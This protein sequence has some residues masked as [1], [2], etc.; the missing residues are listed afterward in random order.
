MRVAVVGAGKMGAHHARV[1]SRADGAELAGVLDV[2]RSA[3]ERVAR[4]HG[5]AVFSS[6]DEALARAD[7][8]VLATPTALHAAQAT[9]AIEAGRSV[10]VEKP[11]AATAAEAR[12]LCEAARRARVRLFVGHSERFNAVVRALA[13]DT[14]NDRVLAIATRRTAA[15]P[16]E[17]LCT[18]LAVHDIDL[19]ALLARAK[20][21]L[22]SASGSADEA[23]LVLRAG[24]ATARARVARGVQRRVRA[25]RIETSRAIYEGD[26]VACTLSRDG[27]PLALEPLLRARRPACGGSADEPLALQAAAALAATR[28]EPSA[29][30][31]GQDGLRAV[32]IAERAAAAL[33]DHPGISAAE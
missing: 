11:L 10:L 3:A 19:A 22:V 31:V 4:D 15:A 26:L 17:N 20:A 32:A 23:E 33:V 8:V 7:L 27:A 25:I 24:A 1:F 2:D 21:E 28:G 16:V 13:A 29:I 14:A 18:N 9:R 5:G 30:A 12:A 6:L